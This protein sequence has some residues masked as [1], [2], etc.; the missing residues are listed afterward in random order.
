MKPVILDKVDRLMQQVH[1]AT[2]RKEHVKARAHAK[3]ILAIDPDN[4]EARRLVDISEAT[5]RPANTPTNVI[6]RPR[7]K[8]RTVIIATCF[9]IGGVL[10]M[11]APYRLRLEPPPGQSIQARYDL[12]V[13]ED[14]LAGCGFGLL[15]M[16]LTWT[17]SK[18]TPKE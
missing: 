1:L 4:L 16:R 5:A 3:R 9:M 18:K 10:L 6:D 2:L 12:N 11:F 14:I 8:R 15:L 17:P 7:S 13:P